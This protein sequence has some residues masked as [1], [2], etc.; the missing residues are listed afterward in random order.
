MELN[1][2]AKNGD[3]ETG[4]DSSEVGANAEIEYVPLM[5]VENSSSPSQQH[6]TATLCG[7]DHDAFKK[8]AICW[9]A[10][11]FVL[12]IIIG[13]A[14]G[15]IFGG[16]TGNNPYTSGTGFWF[17]VSVMLFPLGLL[18]AIPLKF[19]WVTWTNYLG[20]DICENFAVTIKNFTL[21]I[22]KKCSD[23]SDGIFETLRK[24]KFFK[25]YENF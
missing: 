23:F 5:R 15:E 8:F 22:K 12:V 21:T 9:F 3:V 4:W 20:Y 24:M 11:W 7:W 6:N 14:D 13:I 18:I 25:G 16:G 10:T 17:W 2:A 19:C 1:D